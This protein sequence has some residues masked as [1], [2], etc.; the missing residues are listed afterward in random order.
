MPLPAVSGGGTNL[1]V[2][3]GVAA[4]TPVGPA[5]AA[6]THI[7]VVLLDPPLQKTDYRNAL[8]VGFG[9]FGAMQRRILEADVRAAYLETFGKRRDPERQRT[10]QARLF[11]STLYVSDMYQNA[12]AG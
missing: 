5:R 2:D 4:N 3:G 12:A 9:V 11:A 1:Y 10:P 8:E 7:D 6:A